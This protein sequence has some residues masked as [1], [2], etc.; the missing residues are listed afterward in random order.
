L[1]LGLPLGPERVEQRSGFY[2]AILVDAHHASDK[3]MDDLVLASQSP[4]RKTL[5]ELVGLEPIIVPP[6][7]VDESPVKNERPMPYALR[8]A[9]EKA[10][11]VDTEAR[12]VIAADTVVALDGEILGKARDAAD[13]E[14][15]LARLSSKTHVVHTA[16]VVRLNDGRP[17]GPRMFSDIVST[18]VRFRAISAREIQAY[19]ATGEGLDK[20]GAYGI[21]GAGGSLVAEVRGSYTNVVGLP[22]EETL[23]LLRLSGFDSQTKS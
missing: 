5:L 22:L 21:Q 17:G 1:I 16:V 19:V 2:P 14:A 9:L 18:L 11:I 12:H 6:M 8:V 3:A 23:R 7:S 20:A 10:K 13:A 4:R 15:M